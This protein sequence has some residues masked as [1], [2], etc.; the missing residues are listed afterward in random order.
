MLCLTLPTYVLYSITDMVVLLVLQSPGLDPRL[1]PT[2][3]PS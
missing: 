1:G 3:I 2:E